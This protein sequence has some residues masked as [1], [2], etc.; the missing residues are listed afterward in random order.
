M[1][2]LTRMIDRPVPG[3]FGD[4]MFQ[5]RMT[6]AQYREV[7]PGLVGKAKTYKSFH[8]EDGYNAIRGLLNADMFL[9]IALG[10]P[11][12]HQ[13]NSSG[14]VCSAAALPMTSSALPI[15]L[16]SLV[17]RQ[18]QLLRMLTGRPLLVS[19]LTHVRIRTTH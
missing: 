19:A 9:G 18:K 5:V 3:A 15:P 4:L 11:A 16:E 2:H 1:S 12:A 17:G 7:Q 10:R 6:A 13:G 8:S 14:V